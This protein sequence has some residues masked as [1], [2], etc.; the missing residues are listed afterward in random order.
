MEKDLA[1]VEA[2][3]ARDLGVHLCRTETRLEALR[4]LLGRDALAADEGLWIR[5]C[6]SVHTFLMSFALDLVYL[7]RHQRVIK[8][9]AGL[10]PWRMSVCPGARAV[11]E[12]AAGAAS[13][14]GIAPGMELAAI[15]RG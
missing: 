1:L 15:R 4:G 2:A 5:G 11:V 14:A 9:V 6:G 10:R 8:I 7:D 3:T 13:A 12:L